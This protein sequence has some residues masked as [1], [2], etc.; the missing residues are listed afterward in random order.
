MQTATNFINLFVGKGFLCTRRYI[1]EAYL[2]AIIS[3]ARGNTFFKHI[4]WRS[5]RLHTASY[6]MYKFIGERFVCTRQQFYK[7]IYWGRFRVHTATHF[8]NIFVGERFVCT[9]EIIL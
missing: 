9:V 5:F 4:Y 1:G 2:M 7:H 6:F 8:M 3:C